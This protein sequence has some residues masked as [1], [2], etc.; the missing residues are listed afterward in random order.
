M[1]NSQFFC[2]IDLNFLKI[3][4]YDQVKTL[5][6]VLLLIEFDSWVTAAKSH[7]SLL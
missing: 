1:K 4:N 7:N 5:R 6:N 2:D 3:F